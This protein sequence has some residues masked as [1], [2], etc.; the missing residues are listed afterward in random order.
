M[1]PDLFRGTAFAPIYESA[2]LCAIDVG[3]RG[4]FD[5][6]LLPVAW[7][8]DGIGF[9]PEPAAF[10]AL[11]DN[12]APWRSL[13]W[14]PSAVGQVN[15]GAILH[16]PPD[17]NGAS[18]LPHDPAVGRR[19]GLEHLTENT[20]PVEV[21]TVTLDEAAARWSLPAADY[22]KLDVEGAELSILKA[23]PRTLARAW[24][25]KAEAS[26]IPARLGQ[27]LVTDLEMF[28]RA[29]GFAL[30]DIQAPMRWRRR[31]V[32]P[33]PYSWRGE[34]AYSRGQIAQCDLIFLREPDPQDGAGCL[35]AGLL[36]MALG[37]FDR[38][39][40]L[41]ERPSAVAACGWEVKP[42]PALAAA[43]RLWGRRAA[44]AAI[45]RNLRELVP[46]IRSLGRGIPG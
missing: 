9:E 23:A 25:V 1:T 28:M 34:P 6:E 3:S 41:F 21:E 42:R 29:Q 27:P 46:L 32:A 45:R 37:F 20:R 38:A 12:P 44:L 15:G 4:G 11:G 13:R 5:G 16:V 19:F 40:D 7:A 17:P 31:P 14:L 2:R 36:A 18:L 22:I 43:S 30:M 10:A 33:H 35:R 39:L 26:F 8:V 24:A